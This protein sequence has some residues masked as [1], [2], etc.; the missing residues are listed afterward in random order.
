[1]TTSKTDHGAPWKQRDMLTR[2]LPQLWAMVFVAINEDG[3]EYQ[4]LWEA[5]TYRAG[6]HAQRL[7]ESVEAV[8]H[9]TGAISIC[10]DGCVFEECPFQEL[11]DCADRNMIYHLTEGVDSLRNVDELRADMGT[12]H[13]PMFVL[14]KEHSWRFDGTRHTSSVLKCIG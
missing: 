2:I 10:L 8:L 9:D 5:D 3:T 6:S 12:F 1:M 4:L 14:V 11:F 13:S 7:S